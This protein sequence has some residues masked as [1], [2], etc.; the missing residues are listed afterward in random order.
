MKDTA[1]LWM[2][3]IIHTIVMLCITL[4]DILHVLKA[5]KFF[6]RGCVFRMMLV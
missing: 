5:L 6:V 4:N 2:N 1:L 3:L